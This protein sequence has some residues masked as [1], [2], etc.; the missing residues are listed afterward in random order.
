[1]TIWKQQATDQ[2]APWIF[3]SGE[4]N[5]LQALQ[6]ERGAGSPNGK[7]KPSPEL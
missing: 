7:G 5:I 1:M 2:C 6:A 4:G 3:T